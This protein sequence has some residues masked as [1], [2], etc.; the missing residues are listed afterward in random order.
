MFT[1][2]TLVT[3]LL[4]ALL[5]P[6]AKVLCVEAPAAIDPFL[7]P[8]IASLDFPE[9]EARDDL[10]PSWKP[11][12]LAGL[13]QTSEEYHWVL[14]G[15]NDSVG[16][17]IYRQKKPP[18]AIADSWKNDE[19]PEDT[20]ERLCSIILRNTL[21]SKV[22][23]DGYAF[24][25]FHPSGFA[26]SVI[27]D[28]IAKCGLFIL[29]ACQVPGDRPCCLALLGKKKPE[30]IHSLVA[31]GDQDTR[32]TQ[33]FKFLTGASTTPPA[34]II[35]TEPVKFISPSLAEPIRNYLRQARN[36]GLPLVEPSPEASADLP[37]RL[38]LHSFDETENPDDRKTVDDEFS[39]LDFTALSE[40]QREARAGLYRYIREWLFSDLGEMYAALLRGQ[41]V[42][43]LSAWA[44]EAYPPIPIPELPIRQRMF[45]LQQELAHLQART[46]QLAEEIW[47]SPDRIGE[48]EASFRTINVTGDDP[49]WIADMPF[50]LASIL[51]QI[52]TTANATVK[53]QLLLKFFEGLASFHAMI[54]MSTADRSPR[55]KEELKALLGDL[56]TRGQSL[57]RAT[58]GTW[59]Q[60]YSQLAKLIRTSLCAHPPDPGR[61]QFLEALGI[62]QIKV[63][64]HLVSKELATIFKDANHLRNR[65]TGHGPFITESLAAIHVAELEALQQRWQDIGARVWRQLR[66]IQPT[67]QAFKRGGMYH[68]TVRLLAGNQQPFA[69]EELLLFDAPECD[70]VHLHHRDSH[71]TLKL[72]PF[73]R[74][75]DPPAGTQSACYFYN[76]SD[77]QGAHYVTYYANQRPEEVFSE[78]PATMIAQLLQ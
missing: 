16:G 9:G 12:P 13:E 58:F 23:A 54:L 1:H 72:I 55:I 47:N 44:T 35:A 62:D 43:P 65:I 10:P 75:C 8:K 77:H 24:C 56:A 73:I 19:E 14:G 7:T 66:L 37:V 20:E 67:L 29:G 15:Y 39:D 2:P 46:R 18:F 21:Y 34:G 63:A 51:W 41:L 27:R 48:H 59:S 17:E 28:R 33:F 42:D 25:E 74:I 64:E 40:Q 70:F 5:P 68:V 30:K 78:D 4:D 57:T 61:G 11:R 50:P 69:A 36:L 71:Q 60:I 3:Q 32:I 53:L 45:S 52:R 6:Q 31:T 49:S 76:R 22:R 38:V 26:C